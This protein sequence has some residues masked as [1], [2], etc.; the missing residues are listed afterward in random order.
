MQ[1]LDIARESYEGS[2]EPTVV[3]ILNA[4]LKRIW[5]KVEAQPDSYIMTGDEFAIFNYFQARFDGN[6][7]ARQARRRFWANYHA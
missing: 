4:A 6:E 2:I 1:A 7:V 3:V 5:A